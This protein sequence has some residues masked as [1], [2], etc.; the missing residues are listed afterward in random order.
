MKMRHTV[1]GII[2]LL[3]IGS[4]GFACET[5]FPPGYHPAGYDHHQDAGHIKEPGGFPDG[6]GPGC[7]AGP[8]QQLNLSQKQMNK[9]GELINRIHSETREMR[10]DLAQRQLEMHRLFTD[11]KIGDA[12]L[13]AKEK[14]LSILRQKLHDKMAYGMIEGRKI[15]TA[16]QLMKLERIPLPW[17]DMIAPGKISGPEH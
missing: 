9:I 10:F 7:Q 13:Q 14:E 6:F 15:L 17:L 5:D 8:L 2:L 4:L 3:M 12:T 11:P 1:V 16:E